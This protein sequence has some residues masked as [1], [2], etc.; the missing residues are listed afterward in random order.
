MLKFGSRNRSNRDGRRGGKGHEGNFTKRQH[1]VV[2]FEELAQF[3]EGSTGSNVVSSRAELLR[4]D[5]Q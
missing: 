1:G 3:D 2:A 5:D 4:D